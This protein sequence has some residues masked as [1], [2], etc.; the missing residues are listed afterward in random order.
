MYA[1]RFSDKQAGTHGALIKEVVKMLYPTLVFHYEHL[2]ANLA[3]GHPIFSSS[4]RNT[5]ELQRLHQHVII[6]NFECKCGCQMTASGVPEATRAEQS[7]AEIR[8]ELHQLRTELITEL[9]AQFEK[10]RNEMSKNVIDGILASEVNGVVPVTHTDMAQLIATVEPRVSQRI[11]ESIAA[12]T[13]TLRNDGFRA[14]APSPLVADDLEDANVQL[15]QLQPHMFDGKPVPYGFRFQA[16]IFDLPRQWYT[17][18]EDRHNSRN[19]NIG[20]WRYMKGYKPLHKARRLMEYL[21]N[22]IREGDADT[23]SSV[24]NETTLSDHLA[25]LPAGEL[26]RIFKPRI[27]E[28]CRRVYDHNGSELQSSRQEN[29]KTIAFPTIYDRS[30][31][32]RLFQ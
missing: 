7:R 2:Q 25:K 19:V 10:L 24:A 14:T 20:P 30:R 29:I 3:A 21:E 31:S 13:E 16:R 5:T 18:T 22:R 1:Q 17:V 8:D 32:R 28:L 12:M 26:H 4:A 27:E 9:P 11:S 15:Q 6:S 23:A